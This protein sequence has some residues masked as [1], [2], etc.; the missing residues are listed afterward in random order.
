M[1]IVRGA[2]AMNYY[3][4]LKLTKSA[5][6]EDVTASFR[7][8]GLQWHPDR[9]PDNPVEARKKFDHI[10]EAYDVLSNPLYRAIFD[11][12]GAKGLKDGVAD[13]RGGIVKGT[14]NY[15]FGANGDSLAIL[16]R[17]FGTDNPFAELFQVSRE[18]FDPSYV[19]PRTTAVVTEIKCT[20]EE[21]MVGGIKVATVN[22]PG[23]GNREVS[24]EIKRGWRDGA[25]LTMTAKDILKGQACPKALQG[26]EFTFVVVE[27]AHPLFTRDGDDLVHNAKIPLVR[28]LS[29]CTLKLAT[30]DGREII[31]GV[32]DVIHAGYEKVLVGEGMPSFDE[33]GKCGDLVIKYTVEF[34][35]T[36]N[37]QQR[38]LLKAA[39]FL[40]TNPSSDQ[41]EA[42]KQMSKV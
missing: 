30:L 14:G 26:A 28:A 22:L 15:K 6:H 23:V 39:L 8:L 11:Q 1:G 33:P 13:G 24:I 5:S 17:V 3:D 4:E 10:C 38:H 29:G 7:R 12:H 20:L 18:F 42:L 16:T 25:K 41:S 9:N 31:V 40:P 2:A 37:D 36:L 19:P 34:P 27:E 21:L 32:N 35:A